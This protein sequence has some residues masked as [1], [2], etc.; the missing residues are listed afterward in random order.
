[1]VQRCREAANGSSSAYCLPADTKVQLEEGI[2]LGGIS[3]QGAFQ[4]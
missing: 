2:K 3:I 4:R 1:M